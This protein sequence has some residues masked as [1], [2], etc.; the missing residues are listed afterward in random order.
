MRSGRTRKRPK[1]RKDLVS[2][3]GRA[4]GSSAVV[5]VVGE[6]GPVVMSKP[7]RVSPRQSVSGAMCLAMPKLGVDAPHR[8]YK[9]WICGAEVRPTHD[10]TEHQIGHVRRRPF[11]TVRLGRP[12]TS[13]APRPVTYPASVRRSSVWNRGLSPPDRTGRRQRDRHDTGKRRCTRIGQIT[14]G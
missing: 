8:P 14:A 13:R 10:G 1:N 12:R 5:W 7:A 3:A 2:P 4:G 11:A 6:A 9:C